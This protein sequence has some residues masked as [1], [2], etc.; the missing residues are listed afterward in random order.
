MHESR[1]ITAAAKAAGVATQM[2]NQNHNGETYRTLVKLVQSGALG[3][4]K[5]AHAWSNRPIWPQGI[6]RPTPGPKTDRPPSLNWDL[7]LGVAPERPFAPGVYHPFKWRG[8]Y[9]FGAGALG[10]MGCHILD[11]IYWALGVDAPLSVRYEGPPPMKETFPK[12][13]VIHYRFPGSELT[14]GEP[15]AVTWYDGDRKPDPAAC[16]L[17]GDTKLPDN[18]CLFVGE[19]GVAVTKHGSRGFPVLYPEKDFADF[20]MEKLKTR[21][22]YDEWITAIKGEGK[23]S[24]S[25]D[26]AGPL[27]EAVLLGCV[28]CR[29]P[30]TTLQWDSAALKFPNSPDATALLREDY[31][32]GWEVEGL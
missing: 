10:D 8:W 14:G 27:S 29:V 19:K 12:W 17:P 18:G 32:K 3:T 15:I 30:D 13:E 28:A 11:P 7:W 24:S 22:H 21:D 16:D 23:T 25:F 4:I 1:Q 31:R 6:E 20:P 26:Y 2:G 5:A 9:D